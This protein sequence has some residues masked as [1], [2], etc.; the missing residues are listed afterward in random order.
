VSEA[1]VLTGIIA[2]G[3]GV[4]LAGSLDPRI[5]AVVSAVV[6]VLLGAGAVAG[7]VA[8]FVHVLR[9]RREIERGE[10]MRWVRAEPPSR[11]HSACEPRTSTRRASET[12]QGSGSRPSSRS[13]PSRRARRDRR[14]ST[15]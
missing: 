3:C 9:I 11:P 1:G 4:A 15:R 2:L 7:G 10:G 12:F 6:I 14:R 5:D 13:S 8:Y